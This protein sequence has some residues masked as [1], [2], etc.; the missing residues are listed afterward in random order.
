MP[1]DLAA[2]GR[3]EDLVER[4]VAEDSQAAVAMGDFHRRQNLRHEVGFVL[5]GTSLGEINA[6]LS[7][8]VCEERD[9]YAQRFLE[10]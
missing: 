3:C 4:R 6:E 10:A 2:R 8:S 7:Y 5:L 1:C 9:A